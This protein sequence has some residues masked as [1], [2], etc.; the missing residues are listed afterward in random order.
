MPTSLHNYG[1]YLCQQKRFA[2][3]ESLFNQALA[4]PQYTRHSVRTS[5]WRRAFARHARA[6]W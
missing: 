1:W 5:C 3:A 4:M 6:T 2:E